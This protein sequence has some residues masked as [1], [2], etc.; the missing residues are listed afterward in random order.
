M[1]FDLIVPGQESDHEDLENEEIFFGWV[2]LERYA[3]YAVLPPGD[4]KLHDTLGELTTHLR[5]RPIGSLLTGIFGEDYMILD[6]E[7][8]LS[9]PEEVLTC[10]LPDSA[11]ITKYRHAWEAEF[12][13]NANSFEIQLT[14]TTSLSVNIELKEF[15]LSKNYLEVEIQMKISNIDLPSLL[16]TV[17]FPDP[18]YSNGMHVLAIS[19]SDDEKSFT[20]Y[21]RLLALLANIYAIYRLKNISQ[22]LGSNVHRYQ[23]IAR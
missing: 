23:T 18:K 6:L 9:F 3:Y 20:Q 7:P 15:N 13:R 10:H 8:R 19:A 21:I 22:T 1:L 16:L 12:P 2:Y 5:F 17:Y 14:G 11:P 4:L